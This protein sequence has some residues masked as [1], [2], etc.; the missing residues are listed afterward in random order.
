MVRESQLVINNDPEVSCCFGWNKRQGVN[1][2]A[3]V[4]VDG[5][6]QFQFNAEKVQESEEWM[7]L[8]ENAQKV[9]SRINCSQI[10][11]QTALASKL[12]KK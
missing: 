2:D 1:I 4:V 10:T 5:L 6:Y 12:K 7:H 11:F 9:H 3:D 8:P